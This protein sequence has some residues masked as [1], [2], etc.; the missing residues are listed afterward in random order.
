MTSSHSS[1]HF[2]TPNPTLAKLALLGVLE[3]IHKY[4]NRPQGSGFILVEA[5][6]QLSHLV[7]ILSTAPRVVR[8]PRSTPKARQR[9]LTPLDVDRIVADYE[10]GLT[11]D[12]TAAKNEVHRTTAMRWLKKRGVKTRRNLRKLN[13]DQVRKAGKQYLLG[14]TVIELALELGVEAETLRKEFRRAGI[15]RASNLLD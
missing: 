7:E 12:Q 14:V 6:G 9:R 5:I 1:L 2:A 3:N 4:K 11:V 8:K 13:D 15:T 10:S